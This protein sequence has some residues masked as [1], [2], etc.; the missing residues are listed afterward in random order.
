MRWKASPVYPYLAIPGGL[1]ALLGTVVPQ[2]LRPLYFVWMAVGLVLGT[3]VTSIILTIVFIVAITPIGL[4]MRL[5]GKDP[6]ER[7]LDP[8]ATSYWITK[9][10]AIDDNSRFEKYF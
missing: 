5:L 10:H 8:E 1:V 2:I 7:K 6:M 4:I 9:K 3:I